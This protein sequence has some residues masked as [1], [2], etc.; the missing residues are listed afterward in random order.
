MA[1]VAGGEV[2]YSAICFMPIYLTTVFDRA[3]S[4]R[5]DWLGNIML[6]TAL[7]VGNITF[8]HFIEKLW[9]LARKPSYC[10]I[11]VGSLL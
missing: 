2:T 5:K 7:M 1:V 8:K 3:I 6:N 4:G 10:H 11:N 9:H